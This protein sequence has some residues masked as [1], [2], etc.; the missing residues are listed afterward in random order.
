MCNQ[1]GLDIFTRDITKL[2]IEITKYQYKILKGATTVVQSMANMTSREN[3]IDLTLDDTDDEVYQQIAKEKEELKHKR[4]KEEGEAERPKKK[5][6]LDNSEDQPVN[7]GAPFGKAKSR[8][9]YL[10]L[11]TYSQTFYSSIYK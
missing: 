3:F 6:K 8:Y 1:Q 4:V 7:N 2:G 5:Q 9:E 11:F 10:I